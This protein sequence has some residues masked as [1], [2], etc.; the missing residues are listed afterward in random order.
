MYQCI[1]IISRLVFSGAAVYNC[2]LFVTLGAIVVYSLYDTE[3]FK[4]SYIVFA[5]CILQAT[6]ITLCLVFVPKV[7]IRHIVWK[8]PIG[9]KHKTRT[10]F[11]VIRT[12]GEHEV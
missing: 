1:Y 11:S 3:R 12:H 4:E 5:L 6:T 7:R 2:S 8:P 10:I 9:E